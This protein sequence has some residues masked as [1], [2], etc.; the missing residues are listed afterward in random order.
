MSPYVVLKIIKWSKHKSRDQTFQAQTEC[1]FAVS[2]LKENGFRLGQHDAKQFA[3]LMAIRI[4]NNSMANGSHIRVLVNII[5]SSLKTLNHHSVLPLR[6]CLVVLLE[7]RVR[8]EFS[9]QTW[10]R[11]ATN[12]TFEGRADAKIKAN[13]F[14][15]LNCEPPVLSCET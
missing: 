13:N 12:I 5:S 7:W 15:W 1:Y 14:R 10:K 4:I 2:V 8:S 9:Y 3:Q 6:I 11:D